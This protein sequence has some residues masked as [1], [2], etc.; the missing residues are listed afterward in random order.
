MTYRNRRLLDLARGESC[1]NC[2]AE[3][4]TIVAAHS[5]LPEHGKAVSLKSHDCYVAFICHR[6]HAWLDQGHGMDPTDTYNGTRHDKK[7]MFRRCMDR[8]ML[9]LWDCKLIKVA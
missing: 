3:D 7:I 1:T 2:G 6:C 4:E 5:N 9:R 8:T